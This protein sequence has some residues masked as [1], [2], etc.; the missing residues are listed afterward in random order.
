M[1]LYHRGHGGTQS[2]EKTRRVSSVRLC[3]LCGKE[4]RKIADR[5]IDNHFHPIRSFNDVM[6]AVWCGP[7]QA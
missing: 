7:C 6:C 5:E 2:G 1:H 4:I 3:V